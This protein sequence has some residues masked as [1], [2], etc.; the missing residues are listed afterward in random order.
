MIWNIAEGD[1]RIFIC[2]LFFIIPAVLVAYAVIWIKFVKKMSLF[3]ASDMNEM[4]QY[5]RTR[6]E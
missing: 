3:K 2:K 1:D 5:A 6:E 4:N